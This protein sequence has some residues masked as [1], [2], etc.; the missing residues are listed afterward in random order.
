MI[1]GVTSL[2]LLSLKPES[3]K[4]SE[5]RKKSDKVGKVGFDFY[6][7]FFQNSNRKKQIHKTPLLLK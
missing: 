6:Q 1:P 7:T 5:S 2:G 4:K 3:L